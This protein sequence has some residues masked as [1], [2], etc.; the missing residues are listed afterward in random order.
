[1][2]MRH[3]V[4]LSKGVLGQ[5]DSP[6]MWTEIISHIPDAVLTKPGVR[7]LV[8]AC[9]HC[10]EAKIIAER[11]IALGV[12]KKNV[13]ESMYLIDKYSMFTNPAKVVYGFKNVI[14]GDFLTWETDMKF[15]AVVG[16]PPYS[17][18]S[19]LL[20]RYFFEKALELGETVTMIMPVNLDSTHDSRKQVNYLIERHSEFISEDISDR[21]D[22]G[23]SN[24]R[25]VIASKKITNKVNKIVNNALDNYKVLH[26]NRNRLQPI[27]GNTQL[28]DAKYDDVNG[29]EIIDKVLR[30]GVSKRK[31]SPSEV[32]K[33]SQKIKTPYAV[34]VN[35]T[36]SKGLFNVH[37]EKNFKT[38]WTMR[39]F[40]FEVNSKKEAENLA[41][42][43]QSDTI[44]KEILKMFKLK[45][46]AYTVT[47]E[48][49]SKL[50]WYE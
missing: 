7:I 48:M 18:G 16:N 26:T 20:Y 15:D 1:M 5:G 2:K 10:T 8:V 6:E 42:W 45:N 12:S 3:V 28:S 27:K 39:V 47:K 49:L 44:K 30:T 13:N 9:G 37:I 23:Q 17:E 43:L 22:V 25:C 36:P 34:F 32:K 31:V 41:N 33:S 14:T 50:P 24:I 29:V 11:M 4:D 35:H 40:A 19:K 38:T 46:N 21:F